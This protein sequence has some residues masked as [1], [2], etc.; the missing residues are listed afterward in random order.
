MGENNITVWL[1][2]W[3]D[4]DANDF[5]IAEEVTVLGENN[6]RPDIVLYVNGI[7]LGV[8]GTE[9]FYRIRGRRHT[10]EHKRAGS[11]L[12]TAVLRHGATSDGGQ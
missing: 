2:D 8:P 9:A 11:G 10:T 7:A 5:A 12:H 6:R 3:D 1:I 4:P